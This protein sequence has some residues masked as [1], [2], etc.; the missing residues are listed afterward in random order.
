MIAQRASLMLATAATLTIIAAPAAAQID[1]GIVLNIMRE[2]AKIDDPSARLACY[3]NN[4]R[5]A[6]ATPRAVVPG[7]GPVVQGGAG[8]PVSSG[9]AEG[10]GRESVRAP[11]RFQSPADQI[12]SVTAIVSQV[13]QRQPGIYVLTLQD[14]AQWLFTEGA[15]R[16]YRLP[17]QGSSITINRAAMDS[18]LMRFDSQGAIRVRRIQ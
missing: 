4:I 18:F 12:D 17:R 13:T 9:G 7:T 8:A 2:C 1:D 10:F 14:G 3:D 5:S 15:P 11:D 16:T 6:G